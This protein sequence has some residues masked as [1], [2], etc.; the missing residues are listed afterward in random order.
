M[1]TRP[2]RVFN[3]LRSRALI[4]VVKMI[5]PTRSEMGLTEFI[6]REDL[7][8]IALFRLDGW[9]EVL[10]SGLNLRPQDTVCVFGAY[11]G[12]SVQEYRDRFE[13][14]V[15]GLEPIANFFKNLRS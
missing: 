10:F 11:L 9:N 7:S 4:P 13:T 12:D 5:A 8:P 14:K 2:R 1:F 15:I 6:S 3:R